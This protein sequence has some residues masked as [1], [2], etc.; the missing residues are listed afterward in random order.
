MV[1]NREKNGQILPELKECRM[2]EGG[3]IKGYVSIHLSLYLLKHWHAILA[4]TTDCN[5][6]VLLVLKLITRLKM[7][8][9]LPKGILETWSLL[10][11]ASFGVASVLE[12]CLRLG[13]SPAE[14]LAGLPRH[15]WQ[16]RKSFP[17]QP[18]CS[19]FFFWLFLE[20]SQIFPSQN[21]LIQDYYESQSAKVK[22]LSS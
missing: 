12:L 6:Q 19:I 3:W 10:T 8:S 2:T 13:T 15:A 4:K 7:I 1:V 17:G 5:E 14:I 11:E 21:Q 9:S 18:P 20:R 16:D 22:K